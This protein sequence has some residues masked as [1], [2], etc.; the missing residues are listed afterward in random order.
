MTS[1]AFR[2]RDNRDNFRNRLQIDRRAEVAPPVAEG[3][4][5]FR[6]PSRSLILTIRKTGWESQGI[7]RTIVRTKFAELR[8]AV[9]SGEA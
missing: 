2:V 8:R 6:I 1:A 3:A 7:L 5:A 4:S 9:G